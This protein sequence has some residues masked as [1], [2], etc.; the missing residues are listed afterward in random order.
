MV[1]FDLEPDSPT[2]FQGQREEDSHLESQN[3]DLYS[4]RGAISHSR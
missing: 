1:C 3:A 2:K 4:P